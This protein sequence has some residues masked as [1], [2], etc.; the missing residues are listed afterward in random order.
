MLS[1]DE[2]ELGTRASG[3]LTTPTAPATS[4]LTSTTPTSTT[5][6]TSTSRPVP[7]QIT[8]GGEE[9]ETLV[10]SFAAMGI[11]P[12]R[13]FDGKKES[14]FR[15]WVS[16]LER[17]LNLVEIPSDKRTNVLLLNLSSETAEIARCLAIH[18]STD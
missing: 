10:R 2:E 13:V 7:S 12:P 5:T 15:H 8:A 9:Q 18:G 16:R 4:V 1:D 11:K 3:T 17:Y 14:N 6:S